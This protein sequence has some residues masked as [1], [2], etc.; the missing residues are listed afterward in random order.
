MSYSLHHTKRNG[1]HLKLVVDDVTTQPSLFVTIYT[2]TKL[3]KKKLG[4]Q[5][6]YLKALRFFYEF[7]ERKHGCTFDG[8]FISAEYNVDSFLKEA[9]HFFEY[10]LSQQHLDGS[11][12]A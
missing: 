5:T 9:D 3:T 2:L 11:V 6:S 8:A 4:T 1:Q 7:Y 10:L 12:V